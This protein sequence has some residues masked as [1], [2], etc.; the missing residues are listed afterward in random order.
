MPLFEEFERAETRPRRQNEASFDYMNVSARPGIHEIR[1]LLERWFEHLPANAQADIQSR[2]TCRDP[3][4]HESAF[5][6]MYW[7]ELLL[8]CGYEVEIHPTLPDV[9]T[10]PD[11]L[12]LQNCERQ[13]YVEATLAMPPGDPAADRR[14][15]ELHDTL[16]RM[17][18][19]DYFL[20]VQFRGMPQGN[21]RGRVVREKLERWLRTC[22][23]AEISRLYQQRDY[24]K[25]PT[26]TWTEQGC[27]LTFTPIPKGP[28]FRGQPGARP[29]GMVMP[30]EMLQLHTNDDIKAAID[31]KATKYG[32]L[33]RPLIVA[34]NV[35]DDFCD[36]DDI[37]N[38]LFG[39][40]QVV[41]VRQANGQIRHDWGCR[42]ANGA[43]RGPRGARNRFVSVVSIVHQLTAST[44]RTRS[45]MLIHNP[46]AVHRLPLDAFPI[47]QL[48]VSVPDGHVHTQGGEHHA[49]I[50]GIPN[51]WPVMD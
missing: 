4:Q 18:S 34:I 27:T 14:V 15:A 39:E 23:H 35:L 49:D 48:T 20:E 12:S 8:S 45:V 2:F 19:P 41:L 43:W 3:A 1:E 47:P 33:D 13:F 30:Q 36:D 42:A 46:W 26:L 38:A 40:E 51:P 28:Q 6:E 9:T 29:V 10:N 17:D 22:D 16:D 24:E 32:D 25:V 21:I 5:F 50:L 44:L 31:G 37:W 7:H 11:F